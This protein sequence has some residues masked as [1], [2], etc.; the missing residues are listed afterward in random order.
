MTSLRWNALTRVAVL[1]MVLG[2]LELAVAG[3]PAAPSWDTFSDTWVATDSLGRSLPTA[4]QVGPPRSNKTVGIFY[5]LW[6]GR[7]GEAGP[8]DITK[9]LAA[10]PQAMTKPDSPLWGPLQ[11]PHHWGESIFGY[12][13]SDDEGVIRKH[14]QML[15]DAEVDTVIFDVT[16]NQTYPQR[17]LALLRAFAEVRRNGG[18]A[19]QIAFLCPFGDP[20]KVVTELWTQLYQPGLHPDLWFRWQGKPL[21]LADPAYFSADFQVADKHATAVPL[22]AGHTLGQ[23]FKADQSLR[24]VSASFPTW[25]TTNAAVTLTLHREGPGGTSVG[26]QRFENITDNGWLTLRFEPPLPSGSYYLEA[27]RPRGTVGW[28]GDTN[29][30]IPSGTAI[31]DGTPGKGDRTLRLGMASG[32]NDQILNFFTFRKPQPD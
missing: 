29:D 7:H 31:M 28:W 1:W 3:A 15:A 6:L 19:P 26:S 2:L 12:Y 18:R 4:T 14:A 25:N 22:R 13:R 5:F 11:V 23:T 10:D 9:I 30:F 24:S 17:Y 16:N 21:L 32:R 8:F 20:R 27:S